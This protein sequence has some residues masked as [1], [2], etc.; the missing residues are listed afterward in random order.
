ML[1]EI[2]SAQVN[3][4]IQSFLDTIN[5]RYNINANIVDS[6]K[7]L[8]KPTVPKKKKKGKMD[9]LAKFLEEK[10]A[11]YFCEE[12]SDDYL[13]YNGFLIID[14]KTEYAVGV[15]KDGSIKELTRDDICYCKD[16]NI[17]YF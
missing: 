12:Y 17:N 14:K 13:I 6:F 4:A 15:L 8:R 1:H 11:T 3:G 2:I 5:S 10:R 9:K 16:L 7:P